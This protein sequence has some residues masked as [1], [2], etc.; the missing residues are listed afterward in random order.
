MKKSSRRW[1]IVAVLVLLAVE[2]AYVVGANMFL[3]SERAFEAINRKPEKLRLH[4]GSGWTLIPGVVHFEELQIRGQDR[5]FQWHAQ[6]D[7]ITT[8][9]SLWAL[10]GKRFRTTSV[11]GS[12]LRFHMRE[13]LPLGSILG[14]EAKLLPEIPG[15]SNPPKRPP[16][17]LYPPQKIEHPW[18]IELRNALITDLREIW[19]NQF[20]FKGRGQVEGGMTHVVQGTVEVPEASVTLSSGTAWLGK[21]PA[22]ENVVLKAVAT[23]DRFHPKKEKGLAMLPFIS[24]GVQIKGKIDSLDFIEIFFRKVPWLQIEGEGQID[25]DVRLVKGVLAPDTKFSVATANLSTNVL[26]FAMAA[27][28]P[29][30]IEGRVER[31]GE[32]AVATVSVKLTDF[33][34]G[35]PTQEKILVR[36]R[37]LSFGG[38]SSKLDLQDP[39]TDLT[40]IVDTP[41]IELEDLTVL[42][43]WIPEELGFK[44]RK[45]SGHMR[46][47]AE[48]SA[49]T[50]ATHGSVELSAQG[51]VADYGDL[52]LATDL[53]IGTALQYGLLEDEKG[54]RLASEVPLRIS[55]L[56][57]AMPN[58][59]V[60]A[61]RR[62]LAEALSLEIHTKFDRSTVEKE[63]MLGLLRFTSGDLKLAAKLPD[64]AYLSNYLPTKKGLRVRSGT[65]EIQARLQTAIGQSLAQ[66]NLGLRVKGL[67]AQTGDLALRGNMTLN[68]DVDYGAEQR[69]NKGLLVFGES[70]YLEILKAAIT[71]DGAEVQE[72]R[73]ILAQDLNL[74]FE[75]AFAPH[76]LDF[77][78]TSGLLRA[79]KASLRTAAEIPNLRHISKYIPAGTGLRLGK[80]KGWLEAEFQSAAGQP[81]ATGRVALMSKKLAISHKEEMHLTSEL[82]L[83]ADL[84]YGET[85]STGLIVLENG[86]LAIA[87]TSLRLKSGR[88]MLR[89]GRA[90]E[91]LTINLDSTFDR[92]ALREI[93][94]REALRA[95][96]ADLGIAG[97]VPDLRFL[98]AYFRQAP[99]L[100]LDG[101]GQMEAAVQVK[102]GVLMPGTR[103][104]VDSEQIQADFMDYT[105]TGSG[106]VRGLVTQADGKTFSRV[107]VSLDDFGFARLK[108]SYIYGSGFTVTGTAERLDLTD[109]FT[110]LKIE[111]DLPESKLPNFAAY[112]S[113]IPPE[114][115]IFIHQGRG[116]IRSHFKFDAETN[117]ATGDIALHAEK[118]IVQF[119][120][121]T[122][123]ADL[124]VNARLKDG[125]MEARSFDMA[126]TEIELTNGYISSD[127]LDTEPGWW[128]RFELSKGKGLFTAPAQ[129]D[130][131]IKMSLR[132]TRPLVVFL[133]EKKGIVRWFKNM[134]TVQNIKARAD[135]KMESEAVEVE[136]LE[137]RGDRL[138][139]L[140]ELDIF[141]RQFAG[142]FYAQLRNLSVAVEIRPGQKKFKLSKSKPWYEKRRLVYKAHKWFASQD[143]DSELFPESDAVVTREKRKKSARTGCWE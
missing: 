23:L 95:V 112:N 130:T 12:G 114:S 69:S 66:A 45:G 73:R 106:K 10:V 126:G 135:F 96:S 84:R 78:K 33:E 57:L 123:A 116:R 28:G 8:S 56:A 91:N 103:I 121:V 86:P 31:E 71:L 19:I 62:V 5:K 129:L 83:S 118:I 26:E 119:D 109:P 74:Q 35:L 111:I 43:A 9:M 120:T 25:A 92:L 1:L 2:V 89:D 128:A 14:E 143:G 142:I 87:G 79:S 75:S 124:S 22:V 60:R 113:Y 127:R 107:S 37:D 15:L 36:G 18:T 24:A 54:V 50:L 39:F 138:E 7:E 122:L 11:R 90:V 97:R 141:A 76:T 77:K 70:G 41:D 105:A 38:K 102:K 80:S 61:K 110:D 100:S 34:M 134:L 101:A 104:T 137:M 58:A 115:C 32:K 4:W 20:R 48:G 136:D 117:S 85:N 68:S 82:K 27:Q 67:D 81:L 94:S 13:R 125:D 132:D 88:L 52:T 47:H 59:R 49:L 133:A 108:Q 3:N 30:K 21:T 55:Q 93:E 140:G 139:V 6:V 63:K 131:R 98:K 51:L 72:R 65:G 53:R 46:L 29:G 17:Q 40:M 99:W 42:N 44:I 64:L 16:E